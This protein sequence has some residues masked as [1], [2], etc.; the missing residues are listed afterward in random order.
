MAFLDDLSRRLTMMGQEAATQTK[1]FAESTRI[2]SK[3][4]DEEKQINNYFV[5]LGKQYFELNKDNPDANGA[6]IIN[7]IKDAQARIG[8][9]KDDL[10]KVKGMKSCSQCGG[11]VPLHA[12]F[13]N[14]CGAKVPA[15]EPA[16]ENTVSN[17]C[18]Q[19]GAPVDGNS[20]FC[21]SCGCN[22][23]PVAT[24]Y[25]SPLGSSLINNNGNGGAYSTPEAAK[26]AD[27][28]APSVGTAPAVSDSPAGS[29]ED[30]SSSVNLNKN[31]NING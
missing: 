16:A 27:I 25:P 3:I 11:D 10:K 17:R 6:D 14:F 31:D 7:N 15:A 26:T 12:T 29:D 21:V 22:L 9:L 8:F 13:C 19:C 20:A 30:V 23:Q 1:M 18:P 5:Q 24:T 4:T 2:N 28:P